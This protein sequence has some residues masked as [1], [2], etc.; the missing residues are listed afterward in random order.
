MMRRRRGNL[1]PDNRN[2]GQ[3]RDGP[4]AEVGEWTHSANGITGKGTTTKGNTERGIKEGITGSWWGLRR[5][6]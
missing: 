1:K 6:G 5:S 2:T 3:G 4:A